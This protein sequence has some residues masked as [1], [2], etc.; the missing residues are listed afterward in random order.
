MLLGGTASPKP[1]IISFAPFR[2]S[3]SSRWSHSM[4]TPG[5]AWASDALTLPRPILQL[6]WNRY[7]RRSLRRVAVTSTLAPASRKALMNAVALALNGS[8]RSST[9]ELFCACALA[10][11]TQKLPLLVLAMTVV[12]LFN[13]AGAGATAPARAHTSTLGLV[14]GRAQAHPWSDRSSAPVVKGAPLQ[15]PCALRHAPRG[16]S[17]GIAAAC[18]ASKASI[19]RAYSRVRAISSWPRSNACLRK[20]STW[21]WCELPSGAVRV[22]LE[23]STEMVVP[24]RSWSW[25]RNSAATPAGS[26]TASTPFLK[27]FSKKMS[28]NDGPMTQRNPAPISAHTADSRDEPQPK[29]SAVTRMCAPR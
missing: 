4:S 8:A 18:F 23:R 26:T 2:L 1:S 14:D 19:S 5:I 28:P 15:T 13:D 22:W 20:G 11:P 3:S 6:Q 16:A 27:Q 21:K 25:R 9:D 10:H 12:P 17:H 24:G 7:A 29:F